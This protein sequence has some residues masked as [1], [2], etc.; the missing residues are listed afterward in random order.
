MNKEYVPAFTKMRNS[1]AKFMEDYDVESWPMFLIFVVVVTLGMSL[2]FIAM[3]KTI[4]DMPALLVSGLFEFGILGWKW[5]GNRKRNNDIQKETIQYA[6]W[7]SVGLAVAMLVINLF[8]ATIEKSV[9]VELTPATSFN[10]WEISAYITIG[11]AALTHVIA[12]LRFDNNDDVKEYN[13]RNKSTQNAIA[14]RSHEADDVIANTQADLKII[15]K[16]QTE[17]GK[18]A[19]DYKHLPIKQLEIVLENARQALLAQYKASPLVIAATAGIADLNK[20]DVIGEPESN[21]SKTIAN[22]PNKK[23]P[24]LANTPKATISNNGHTPE[25]LE[26]VPFR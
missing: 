14:Q 21:T 15:D 11:I 20:D 6:T 18:L 26:E 5:G 25:V 7:A 24:T 8:R 12:Y 9:S 3:R 1:I 10:G 16:I 2:N 13:R 22:A 23:S 19:V 4:G 17:L